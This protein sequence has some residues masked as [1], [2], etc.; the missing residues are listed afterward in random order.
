MEKYAITNMQLPVPKVYLGRH[1]S[2]QLNNQSLKTT[3]VV[4][5]KVLNK[6]IIRTDIQSSP[7]ETYHLRA[8]FSREFRARFEYAKAT[9]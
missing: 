2:F 7:N 6:Y 8:I 9:R 3:D 5:T 1:F 4:I